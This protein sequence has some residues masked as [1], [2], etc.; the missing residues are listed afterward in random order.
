MPRLRGWHRK[1]LLAGG[2]IAVLAVIASFGGCGSFSL[3]PK[4]TD[5]QLAV[6]KQTHF[7][8]TV[9]VEAYKYP[10]YSEHLLNDLRATGLFDAVEPLDRIQ[11]PTLIARVERTVYGK[12][13]IPLWTIVT[14][15]IVPT[16]VEEEHGHV[17]SFHPVNNAGSPVVVDYRYRGPS[18]LGWIATFL[19]FSSNRTSENPIETPRFREG[20]AVA[21][22]SRREQIASLV[23]PKQLP[24]LSIQSGPAQAPAADFRR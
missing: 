7:K 10:I 12:A 18:T 13:T 3:P 21:V 1:L 6:L 17:F 14:L 5:S 22:S 15:G 9:G 11:N 20:L 8:A 2:I 4:P 19:N 24:N 23:I 16:T